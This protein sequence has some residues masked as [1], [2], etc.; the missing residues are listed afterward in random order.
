MNTQ[1]A[2]YLVIFGIFVILLGVIGYQTHGEDAFTAVILRG[3]FG[4]LM[5]LCGILGARGARLGWPVALFAV[6]ILGVACLW[7]ASLGWLAVANGQAERTFASLLS[8]LIL[9]LGGVML[10]LLIKDRKISDINNSPT[11]HRE[12]R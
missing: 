7:R 11:G 9:A 8:T 5:I 6:A 1:T 4:G 2:G 10:W 3:T 12:W